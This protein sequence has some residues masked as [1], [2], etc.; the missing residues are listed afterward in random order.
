ML[1]GTQ[2]NVVTKLLYVQFASTKFIWLNAMATTWLLFLQNI[3][4]LHCSFITES[5]NS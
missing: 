5:L 1:Y 3:Q 4:F 2:I